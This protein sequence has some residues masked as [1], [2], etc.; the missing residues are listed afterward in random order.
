MNNIVQ[1][2]INSKRIK[3]Y[4]ERDIERELFKKSDLNFYKSPFIKPFLS[5]DKFAIKS[6]QVTKTCYLEYA[7]LS[8]LNKIITVT[9]LSPGSG[10]FKRQ[11]VIYQ[12]EDKTNR[13][14]GSNQLR[15]IPTGHKIIKDIVNKRIMLIGANAGYP[16]RSTQWG[17]AGPWMEIK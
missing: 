4:D 2:L 6:T 16:N 12:I 7:D 3:F 11:K 10:Y 9:K 1:E 5:V 15:Y 14:P 13:S 8:K 17:N